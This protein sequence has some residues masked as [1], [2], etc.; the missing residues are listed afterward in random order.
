MSPSAAKRNERV[1][2]VPS[3]LLPFPSWIWTRKMPER[4]FI[5]HKAELTKQVFLNLRDLCRREVADKRNPGC[6]FDH[7]FKRAAKRVEP[8]REHDDPIRLPPVMR[9]ES[10]PW[11]RRQ[12][13]RPTVRI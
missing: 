13:L 8:A 4:V 9:A 11:G 10:K 7:L 12:V 3:R 5:Q 6:L 2:C 1:R